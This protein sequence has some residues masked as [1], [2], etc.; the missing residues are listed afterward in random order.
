[1]PWNEQKSLGFGLGL[2]TRS[3]GLGLEVQSLGFGL[4]KKVLFTSL[5][6]RLT[7]GD[8]NHACTDRNYGNSS[9]KVDTKYM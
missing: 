9:R 5:L 2:G 6:I 4:D 7:K 3:L 1:M 8:T